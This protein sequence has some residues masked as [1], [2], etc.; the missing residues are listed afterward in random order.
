M[1]HEGFALVEAP[2]V[3]G[4]DDVAVPGS[5]AAETGVVEGVGLLGPLQHPLGPGQSGNLVGLLQL[6][7]DH[8][9]DCA[10]EAVADGV[11]GAEAGPGL[12]DEDDGDIEAAG[13]LDEVD[14]GCGSV[15]QL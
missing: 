1:D 2:D 6:V 10:G 5:L 9:A 15:G 3:V 11:V 13:P 12:G 8:G 14:G 4:V 7:T